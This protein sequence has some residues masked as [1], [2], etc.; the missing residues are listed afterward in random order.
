MNKLGRLTLRFPLQSDID[1][2]YSEIETIGA[3]FEEMQGKNS[4]L[5]AQLSEKDEAYNQLLTEKIQAHHSATRLGEQCAG[6]EAVRKTAEQQAGLLQER[7]A[8]LETRLQVSGSVLE[9]AI[10]STGSIL[11]VFVA[12]LVGTA[13]DIDALSVSS[14][15]PLGRRS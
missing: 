4:R 8:T 7:A 5:L 6:A 15:A 14:S 12:A 1:A 9:A 2:Y 3:A 10:L 13:P 11:H